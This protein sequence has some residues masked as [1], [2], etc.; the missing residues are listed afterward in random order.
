MKESPRMR[1]HHTVIS[2][3]AGWL[4][5]VFEWC[6]RLGLYVPVQGTERPGAMNQALNTEN[7]LLIFSLSFKHLWKCLGKKIGCRQ[8]QKD[9]EFRQNS[10][11]IGVQTTY[12]AMQLWLVA[13]QIMGDRL[14][15]STYYKLYGIEGFKALSGSGDTYS[16]TL[17]TLAFHLRRTPWF[18]QHSSLS[19]AYKKILLLSA[20]LLVDIYMRY[21]PKGVFSSFDFFKLL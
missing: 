21:L 17:L 3:S 16:Q 11:E 9:S 20:G 14:T 6:L 1:S 5:S 19:Q 18:Q 2:L 15:N 13:G 7:K 12:G 10:P 8:R 4:N